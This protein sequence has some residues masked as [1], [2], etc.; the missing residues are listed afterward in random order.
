M[1]KPFSVSLARLTN[2]NDDWPIMI[3]CYDRDKHTDELIGL[4]KTTYGALK[5]KKHLDLIE[6]S[7]AKKGGKY[8][9]SGVL[10][11]DDIH[12]FKIPR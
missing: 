8:K 6:P 11:I 7:K 9:N 1:W 3:E 10:N 4:V 12:E 2:N 5:T